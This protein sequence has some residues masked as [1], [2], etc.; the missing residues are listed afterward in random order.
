MQQ[1][2]QP[3]SGALVKRALST[4]EGLLLVAGL[5]SMIVVLVAALSGP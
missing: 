3:T 5:M 4:A 1:L 2:G